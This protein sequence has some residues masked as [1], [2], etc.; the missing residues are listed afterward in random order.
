MGVVL[1]LQGGMAVGKTTAAMA[2]SRL[3]PRIHVCLEDT[4][5]V[6]ARVKARSLD[7]RCFRD[8]VEIQRLWLAN[9]VR[10]WHE[11][12]RYPLSLMDYG[13]EEIIF[14]TLH[15]PQ[16]IGMDWDVAAA[17]RDSLLEAEACMPRRILLLDAP[18]E[19]L[20]RRREADST[21]DRGFFEH[22]LTRLLPLKRPW[23]MSL[24]MTDVLDTS[25][26]SPEETTRAVIAWAERWGRE[27]AHP[28][29]DDTDMI[30]CKEDNHHA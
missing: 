1:S 26:L 8:Y 20:R 3:A 4:G 14:Y 13:A 7:K 15:Y 10:R 29:P 9:E 23:L 17:L 16:T 2:V 24:G 12:Q 11:A 30:L 18:E 27:D 6:V 22:S 19:T 25:G 5:D 28:M 21:R